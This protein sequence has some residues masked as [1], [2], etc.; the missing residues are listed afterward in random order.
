[1]GPLAID[2]GENPFANPAYYGHGH[3]CFER[4]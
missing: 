4:L 2:H 3:Q 1:M